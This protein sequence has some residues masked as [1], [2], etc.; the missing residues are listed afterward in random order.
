MR[1]DTLV[2]G[3]CWDDPEVCPED[4][5]RFD[6]CVTVAEGVTGEGEI[7]TQTI[8]GGEYAMVTHCGPY[9]GL[10][11]AYRYL[12]GTWLP[13]SGREPSDAPP[14]EVYHRAS[15]ETPAEEL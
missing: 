1:G 9:A 10:E 12:F 3:V 8:A 6:C 4:K 15:C 7:G 11:E 5:L 14:F 2:L 13:E